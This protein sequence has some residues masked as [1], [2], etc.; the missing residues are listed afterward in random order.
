MA[1]STNRTLLSL[2][3]LKFNLTSEDELPVVVGVVKVKTL[4]LLFF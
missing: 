2:I 1:P 3:S 4:L